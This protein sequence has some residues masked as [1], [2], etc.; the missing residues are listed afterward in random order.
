M[1][2]ECNPLIALVAYG[3]SD[4]WLHANP[5]IELYEKL[6]TR[7]NHAEFTYNVCKF[8]DNSIASIDVKKNIDLLGE[9]FLDVTSTCDH[10]L[11]PLFLS[12]EV[13]VEFEF[14]NKHYDEI[15][16]VL[17]YDTIKFNKKNK[18]YSDRCG[19]ENNYH[20]MLNIP[21][22]FTNNKTEYFPIYFV[23]SLKRIY[24]K[25]NRVSSNV[26][27]NSLKL[28]YKNVSLDVENLRKE[29]EYEL[30]SRVVCISHTII[31]TNK[32][33]N[34]NKVVLRLENLT[35]VKDLQIVVKQHDSCE[36]ISSY[37]NNITLK[38]NGYDHMSLNNLMGYKIIP[39]LMYKNCIS[40]GV[41][42]MTFCEDP[43]NEKHSHTLDIRFDRIN[44][45]ELHIEFNKNYDTNANIDIILLS[46]EYNV[47]RFLHG[48]CSLAHHHGYKDYWEK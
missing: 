12:I 1:S 13:H 46:R 42:C 15:L 25:C 39:E 32:F 20:Y 34:N 40:D 28:V 38:L 16:E 33:C 26:I 41:F 45:A 48:I 4:M 11:I 27:H 14:D 22:F 7:T 47:L 31:Y 35:S 30:R 10:S 23:K 3:A 9:C 36:N 24:F 6:Y 44:T 37:V 19:D 2:N 18:L 8:D 5:N 21:F 17:Y 43:L 29:K